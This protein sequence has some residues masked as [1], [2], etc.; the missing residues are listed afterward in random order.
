MHFKRFLD[1]KSEISNLF[2]IFINNKVLFDLNE[3]TFL[4]NSSYLNFNNFNFKKIGIAEDNGI[5]I[6]VIDLSNESF[7]F[8][9][10]GYQSLVEYDLRYLM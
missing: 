4:L 7:N 5:K 2:I 8:A 3:K 9:D 1:I 10:Q 6:Y